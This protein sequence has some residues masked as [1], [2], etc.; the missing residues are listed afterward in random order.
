VSRS[1]K[2][3]GQG[4]K[5]ESPNMRVRITFTKTHA[6]RYTSHLDLHRTWERTIRRAQLPLKYSQGFNPRP[7]IN[8]A[9]ALPLGIT[10]DCEIAEIW[11]NQDLPI[12]QVHNQLLEAVPPGIEIVQVESIDTSLSKLPNLVQK[13]VYEATLLEPTPNL[14]DKIREILSSDSIIRE[15][16]GKEYDLRP[17]I[18]SIKEIEVTSLGEQRIQF[19]LALRPSATGRPDELLAVLGIPLNRYRIKRKELILIS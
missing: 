1:E 5:I 12:K 18:H 4:K 11:L 6:M 3:T 13:A 10:S 16:R 15:R 17:L 14:S 2:Q 19:E 8:L 7:K 9:A